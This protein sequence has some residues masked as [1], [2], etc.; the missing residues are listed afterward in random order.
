MASLVRSREDGFGDG[1]YVFACETD[2]NPMQPTALALVASVIFPFVHA[3][4]S[5]HR[6]GL[7]GVRRLILSLGD[8]S[9]KA[10]VMS[11]EVMLQSPLDPGQLKRLPS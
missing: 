8:G 9:G 6:L 5:V 4:R 7:F 2:N 11:M 3:C 1:V 10:R